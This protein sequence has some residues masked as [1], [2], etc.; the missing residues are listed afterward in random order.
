VIVRATPMLWKARLF[1]P[2][3]AIAFAW[4]AVILLRIAP[5]DWVRRAQPPPP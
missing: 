1:F 4:L 2:R 3:L 5:D